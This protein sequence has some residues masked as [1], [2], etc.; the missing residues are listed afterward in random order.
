MAD[1]MIEPITPVVSGVACAQPFRRIAGRGRASKRCTEIQRVPLPIR[2]ERGEEV[3][4][5]AIG[6]R[7]RN[8]GGRPIEINR[9]SYTCAE[10]LVEPVRSGGTQR[11]YLAFGARGPLERFV[12]TN[13]L[14]CSTEFCALAASPPPKMSRAAIKARVIRLNIR[15]VLRNLNGLREISGSE[16]FLPVYRIE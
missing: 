13:P 3:S 7:S 1:R 10:M 6:S 11:H 9:D 16:F 2:A 15:E 12:K 8:C 14:C 5:P 4:Y